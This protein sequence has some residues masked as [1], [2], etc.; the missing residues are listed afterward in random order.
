MLDLGLLVSFFAELHE[1]EEALRRLHAHHF[2]RVAMLRK[3]PDGHLNVKEL[4]QRGRLLGISIGS[5]LIGLLSWG[6]THT[7]FYGA[8]LS[9]IL[10][11]ELFTLVGMLIGGVGGWLAVRLTEKR[12]N[13]KLLERHSGWIL[14]E[15]C[16]VYLQA[17]PEEMGRAVTILRGVGETQPAIFP[18]HPER[19]FKARPALLGEG[20]RPEAQIIEYAPQ[21]AEKHQAVHMI[22]GEYGVLSE[23]DRASEVLS[24]VRRDFS[25]AERLEQNVSTAG[26]W[27]LDN[28]YI[29][30]GH[31]QEVKR[32]LPRNYYQ[33]LPVLE[34]GPDKGL[35]RVYVVARELVYLTDGRLD[36]AIIRAFLEAYQEVQVLQ[37]AELWAVPLMVRI[38]LIERLR[39]LVGEVGQR[40][41]EHEQ[42]DF[43][44]NRLLMTTR[45]DPGHLFSTLASFAQ[46]HPE[47]N[48]Y[49]AAQIAGHLYDE[50]ASLVP[51]QNWFERSLGSSMHE[52]NLQEQAKQAGDQISIGN[53]ITTLRELALLDWR[54]VFEELSAVEASLR[55]DPS[56]VYAG[57]DFDTRDRYRRFVEKVAR[58]AGVGELEVAGTAVE[59]AKQ[60][61]KDLRKGHVGYYLIDEGR[62]EL[63]ESYGV[64]LDFREQVTAWVRQHHTLVYLTALGLAT[65]LVLGIFLTAGILDWHGP[66]IL[67]ALAGLAA[68]F[69]ASQFAVYLVNYL[70]TKLIPPWV[71][72]KR[73]FE[74]SGIPSE[75][76][77]LVVVPMILT[78]TDVVCQEVDKLEIRYLANPEKNL[79]FSLF[80]DFVDSDEPSEAADDELLHVAK[81][82]I[83]ALSEK[84]G[85]GRFFLFSR[86][87]EWCETERKYVGW[88][89]KRG[90]LMEL[91]RYL[92]GETPRA[93]EILQ[94]GQASILQDVRY[95]ITLDADT[96]MP[97]NTA[98]RMIE[99]L[100]H[101]LNQP[102]Y[103]EEGNLLH[104]YTVVQPRVSTALPSAAA[105]PFS[106]LATDPIGADPYTRAISDV[107]QDLAGE[108]SYIGKGIYDLRAFHDILADRFPEQFLLSH[109]LLEGAHVRVGLASDIELFDDFPPDYRT[110]IQ[111]QHRWV[112]G[113]WQIADWI[114]PWVPAH[115]GSRVRNKLNLFN[116]WK[117]FDNLRRSL[118]ATG[119]VAMLLAAWLHSVGLGSAAAVLTGLMIFFTPLVEPFN[120]PASRAAMGRSSWKRFGRH[121]MSALIELAVLPHRAAVDLDAILRVWYRRLIS[122]KKLLE[123]TP[124]QISMRKAG[125]Q[126]AIFILHLTGVSLFALLL[127]LLLWLS[128]P[129]SLNVS[130]PFL[131][132]W[133]LTPA[134][135]IWL[136]TPPGRISRRAQLSPAERGMMRVI[137]RKTWRYFDDFVGPQTNWLPPDNYQV[138]HQNQ[139]AERTSPTNIGLWMLGVLSAHDLG[140]LTVSQAIERLT[141]TQQTLEKLERYEGH[142]LNW[143]ATDSLQPLEPCYVSSV[144]SGNLLASLWTL[145]HGL[146]EMMDAPLMDQRALAGLS[147]CLRILRAHVDA[148]MNNP[149][150]VEDLDRLEELC[151]PDQQCLREILQVLQAMSAPAQHVAEALRRAPKPSSEAVYWADQMIEALS[152]WHDVKGRYLAWLE[153]SGDGSPWKRGRKKQ[154]GLACEE[155]TLRKLAEADDAC[156]EALGWP[157]DGKRSA[158]K[159]A[160]PS[161]QGRSETMRGARDN[162]R[163][164]LTSIQRLQDGCRRTAKAVNMRF[165][166]DK[167]RRLFSIGY[168]V[169]QQQLDPSFYDLLASEAR[170]ASFVAIARGD[171]PIDHWLALNRPY[172][173]VGRRRALL[174]WTGTMFEYLMPALFQRVYP[175]SLLDQGLQTAVTLQEQYG[176]R[177][178]VP[179][180]ISES[181]YADLGPDKSYMYKAFGVPALGL[182][183]GLEERLVVAPYASVLALIE[184]AEAALKNLQKLS[185]LGLE[186]PYGFYEAI[187]FSRQPREQG[188]R[189]VIVR[190][191]MAHHQ[192]MSLL[193][194][195]NCLN[196]Q[197]NQRRF[198]SDPRV[199]AV[200][201]LLYERIPVEPALYHVETR[202]RAPEYAVLV[203]IAPSE[204]K[205]ETP[206]SSVPRVQILSNGKYGV[207][208]T[209]AGGGYSQWRGF[210]I[211]RW[212]ADTT[213]DHWG[214]FCYLR[215]VDS[216]F[217]WSAP[218]HP[219]CGAM[220]EFEVTFPLDKAH[221]RRVDH[222]IET[223][224]EVVVSPEED[225]EL[226]QIT[227]RN[228]S[229]RS[230]ILEITSYEELALAPPGADRQ[231]PAFNKMFI[232]TE[233][234]KEHSALLAVRRKREPEEPSIAVGHM[235]VFDNQST[236]R[237]EYET[238]RGRFIGRG[239]TTANPV[240]MKGQLSNSEGTVL[241]PIFSLRRT[242]TLRPG[243]RVRCTLLTAAAEN[244][245]RALALLEKFKDYKAIERAL[246]MAWAHAQLELRLIQIQP[247]QA[248]RFR[249]LAG[250]MLYPN[251][252]LR[253]PMERLR[254]NHLGQ[255]ALWAYG[256]SG[257]LP[258]A[259]VTIGEERDIALVRQ[260]LQA[261]AYWRMHGLK[262]DLLIINEEVGG[263]EQPLHSR[264]L[265]MAQAYS[266]YTGIDQPGGIYVRNADHISPED[267]TLMLSVARI[268]LIAARGPLA[269]QLSSIEELEETAEQIPRHVVEEEPPVQLRHIKLRVPNGIGGFTEDGREY[270][271]QVNQTVQPPAPWV[272]VMGNPH[273]GTLVS[274]QGSGFTWYGNS[275][276]NRLVEWSN[277]ATCDPPS[278][279]IYI[280]DEESGQFWTPTPL[281]IREQGEYRVRHGAGYSVF[282]YNGHGIEHTMTTFVP[283][284]DQGGDPLRIQRLRLRNDSSG[285]RTLSVTFYVEWTLGEHREASQM[286]VVTEW[287]PG[288][289]ALLARNHYHEEYGDRVCFIAMNGKTEDYTADRT[290]F[291]GRNGSIANPVGMSMV[292]LSRRIGAGLDPCG[293]LRITLELKPG[294]EEDVLCFLGQAESEDEVK[295]LIEKYRRRNAAAEAYQQTMDWW[296]GLLGRLKVDVPSDSINLLLNRWL[297]YQ[298]LSCRLWGRSAFYQSGGAFGFR[299]QLQ[300]VM[301]L[302]HCAPRL[303]REHILVAAGRQFE[304]GDVQHWWHPP[305][306]AGVRTRISDDLLWLPYAVA[307][308]VR[309]SG[310]IDV[311]K[312]EIPFLKG[313]ALGAEEQERFFQPEISEQKASLYEHCQRAVER[314]STSGPHGLPLIGSGDWNDGLNRLGIKGKGESVWLAWFLVDVLQRFAELTEMHDRSM[315]AGVYRTRAE[316]LKRQIEEVA[317]DGEWYLRAF[318]DDGSPIGSRENAEARIFSLPQSW[319]CL[320]GAADE[321]HVALALE[322]AWTE[323][324]REQQRLALLFKPPFDHS[325]PYPGYIM[326]YPPGVRENGGQYTHGAIWYAMALARKGDGKRAVQLLDMLSP[327]QHAAD[328]ERVER[329]KVEPYAVAADI[330]SLQGRFGQGG[331]TWYTGSAGWMYRAWIEEILGLKQRGDKLTLD[332]VIP[333]QWHGFALSYRYGNAVYEFKV[334][335][336]EGVQQGVQW[337]E[338]DGKRLESLI[339][340]LEARPI[341]HRVLVR[342]GPAKKGDEALE[343]QKS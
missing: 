44:A 32:N 182:K 72:P 41:R 191:M 66:P 88:E 329:Y 230:R 303:A 212:R 100:A 9:P 51:V 292:G 237:M 177:H 85:R 179:W 124:M 296:D 326:G 113:D 272:N 278:E 97:K 153:P 189:G 107:Y 340:T 184:D 235:L 57:M 28:T 39:D 317:W 60:W 253:P 152:A 198:H 86:H 108:G 5:L 89:R 308:Y 297:L 83:Q 84:Y 128:M 163:Q 68:L 12:I 246:E 289:S 47:P 174:S 320:A 73:S 207:M 234:V 214:T 200:E 274:E 144:D 251:E 224:T 333:A 159:A 142:L 55:R 202:G 313:D 213:R 284:D 92:M 26:E 218:Y 82:R 332:P 156:L 270:V 95:I 4:T 120:W 194:L 322:S 59:M 216:D 115:D 38:A 158:S 195:N 287:K 245:E 305:S 90:K 180:G 65:V 192:G 193:A 166:Y 61:P 137:A 183:R 286:H 181:A 256:I 170:L 290:I 25:Q 10:A 135:G 146:Q 217:L 42:A 282:E 13:P 258:I 16:V 231:H 29:V 19:A 111:R 123:W 196:G 226:R 69:P 7:T 318:S 36:R 77:T 171:V 267:L 129:G 257:D 190:S 250:H 215:D 232:Q 169:G 74:K 337:M 236:I 1:A 331:W 280:R 312:E 139:L 112:R 178:H 101:P 341:K 116:R 35:P 148:E 247:D 263:Y 64:R 259:A 56:M 54:E 62:A 241:D 165:L 310:D 266:T 338:M 147:D 125:R 15:E 98:R 102:V 262:A 336:P 164:M 343:G 327:I 157:G 30:E 255:S 220:E 314:G 22:K 264:L 8:N 334:E 210:D 78:S 335:N 252:Q 67:L 117:I 150:L 160:P 21:L 291:L 119:T 316:A 206:H 185:E 106:R 34:E 201:A 50:E 186:S 17:P 260:M 58:Q 265:Q 80:S 46:E 126:R 43:W 103:D 63:L 141:H 294:Q 328:L 48:G 118:V 187:D 219:I 276:R 109:D 131:L 161:A 271:I 99:T 145:E 277:D 133:A 205:F 244:R 91:N 155:M 325:Q 175:N 227:L 24:Q 87:R 324:V 299:D 37:T 268:S 49:F 273:L 209:N 204:S 162:A 269:Q 31:I 281:P 18:M 132:L 221:F 239:R 307:Q 275:Q 149:A 197:P 300:D 309:I 121:L 110:Y 199:K 154:Q 188:G 122:K 75:F 323:L 94:V 306:G 134:I 285:K 222:G 330:Y 45:Y 140:Y 52:I 136:D 168:S 298:T 71:L 176:K 228:L 14:P 114:T 319:A 211:S 249:Q 238:E 254:D 301:A 229:V 138:S 27:I 76:R 248:R 167:Q 173:L 223:T 70:V 20:P 279:A 295:A 304:G 208:I 143:Y 339:I 243:Q 225:V 342:L 240:A 11:W 81:Q 172:G 3:T 104:G 302:L 130:L 315:D 93:G 40:L 283:L 311:L 233:S 288:L 6:V 293:A 2:R 79:L 242:I 105:T 203:E 151:Q 33:N 96:Q 53:A 261:H 23:L 127:A 321:R